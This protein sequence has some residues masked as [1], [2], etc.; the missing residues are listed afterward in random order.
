MHVGSEWVRRVRLLKRGSAFFALLLFVQPVP[1]SARSQAAELTFSSYGEPIETVVKRLAEAMHLPL[2]VTPSAA[3]NVVAVNVHA[4]AIDRVLS[5]LA[6]VTYCEWSKASDGT[7]WLKS[8]ARSEARARQADE[9]YESAR[10]KKAL[11]RLRASLATKPAL[12]L[13]SAQQLVSELRALRKKS[14]ELSGVDLYRASLRR[15]ALEAQGPLGEL[16]VRLLCDLGPAPYATLP[17]GIRVTFCPSPHASQRPLPS[18]SSEAFQAFK[19]EQ[20]MWLEALHKV[21]PTGFERRAGGLS[22]QSLLLE[23]P[24][25]DSCRVLLSLTKSFLGKS[26]EAELAIYDMSGKSLAQL[27]KV[28]SP[29]DAPLGKEPEDDAQI[30]V[31][32]V[33]R[34]V[35]SVFEGMSAAQFRPGFAKKPVS[36]AVRS[37]LVDPEQHEPLSFLPSDVLFGIAKA[38]GL[39][40]VASIPDDAIVLNWW[41]RDL[42]HLTV[43]E[44]VK[45]CRTGN[46]SLE[47]GDGFLRVRPQAPATAHESAVSRKA[48]GALLKKSV[49]NGRLAI[50]DMATY[51]L[52]GPLNRECDFIGPATLAVLAPYCASCLARN[53]WDSLRLFGMLGQVDKRRAESGIALPMASLSPG[54]KGAIDRI[55]YG[56]PGTRFRLGR[57]TPAE[58]TIA[59]GIGREPSEAMPNGFPSGAFLGLKSGQEA[60]LYTSD[61]NRRGQ[62]RGYTPIELGQAMYELRQSGKDPRQVFQHYQVVNRPA[63]TLTFS[64]T[65]Y[66]WAER[67]LSATDEPERETTYAGLPTSIRQAIERELSSLQQMTGSSGGSRQGAPP[68]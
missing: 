63:V 47:A 53:D 10:Y 61:A 13:D 12:T 43:G 51:A 7:Y 21:P 26:T 19:E 20:G 54:A 28:I 46:V 24:V 52:G 59:R 30:A 1:V 62:M 44:A 2:R 67:T 42:S 27:R 55:A 6:A 57:V 37:I 8:T 3:G 40:L 65:K 48:L 36:E 14:T 34:Q 17:E 45:V 58:A 9:E 66:C 15:D 31:R 18:E 39:N 64:F 5:E 60:V 35:A 38:K 23:K 33:S 56:I 22:F 11:D 16:F 4:V 41:V 25:A 32:D 49:S 29:D 68:P 50:D